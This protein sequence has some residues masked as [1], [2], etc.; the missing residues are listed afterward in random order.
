MSH[1]SLKCSFAPLDKN[2]LAQEV[3]ILAVV[4]LGVK[5]VGMWF[6]IANELALVAFSGSNYVF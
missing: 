1:A 2:T 3:N 5:L 6:T 4:D